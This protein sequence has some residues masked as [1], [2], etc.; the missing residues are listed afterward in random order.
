VRGRPA[1]V[2]T[3]RDAVTGRPLSGAR[4]EIAGAARF[5]QWLQTRAL[6]HGA[7]WGEL[8]ERADR[9]RTAADGRFLFVD[10]PAGR[11]T[12]VA[13]LPDAGTR[14]GA[15]RAS[16]RVPGEAK[17]EVPSVD[18]ALPPTMLAGT[19]K[20]PGSLPVA[21]ARVTVEGSGESTLTDDAGA[22]TLVGL[23]TGARTVRAEG[24]GF[25][26]SARRVKVAT[27]G[28]KKTADLK[29]GSGS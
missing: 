4:V 16:A 5:K 18:L 24:R 9:V 19:V 27:P 14:Y 26:P 25:A 15:A 21:L 6:P 29:L 28:A 3:V 22:F 2:G 12:I 17:A 11:Y 10:L 13:T 23:E 8:E 7:Q 20:G 1:I